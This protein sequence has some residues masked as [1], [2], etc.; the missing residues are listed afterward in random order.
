MTVQTLPSSV[1]S[2]VLAGGEGERIRPCIQQWLGYSVQKQYCT[3]VG[4]RSML[5]HTWDRANHIGLPR[6]KGIIQN[7]WFW[8]D[9]LTL[10][11]GNS[12][13]GLPVN[14]RWQVNNSRVCPQLSCPRAV[15]CGRVSP[16]QARPLR[17]GSGQAFCFGKRPQNH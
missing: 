8:P 3:F 5:Q 16:R 10:D 11:I 7:L 9:S 2:I 14:N 12:S 1:W 4:T 15:R 17:L 13:W 6:K